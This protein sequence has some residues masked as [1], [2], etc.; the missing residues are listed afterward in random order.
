MNLWCQWL[1]CCKLLR[2]RV[3]CGVQASGVEISSA[4]YL[5]YYSAIYLTYYEMYHLYLTLLRSKSSIHAPVSLRIY[6]TYISYMYS[7]AIHIYFGVI[8]PKY[9]SYLYSSLDVKHPKRVKSRVM[10]AEECNWW[11]IYSLYSLGLSQSNNTHGTI[12]RPDKREVTAL[13]LLILVVTRWR[14]NSAQ[15]D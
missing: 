8:T 2:S 7:Y 6:T 15:L 12:P 10:S 4:I 11:S 1:R 5:T 13:K 3:G 9:T 14:I